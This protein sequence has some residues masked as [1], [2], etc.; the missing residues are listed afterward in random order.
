MGVFFVKGKEMWCIPVLCITL[1]PTLCLHMCSYVIVWFQSTW[2]TSNKA[3]VLLCV[4]RLSCV[5]S[6]Y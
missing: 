4:V 5:V 6:L 1:L 3:C 2:L